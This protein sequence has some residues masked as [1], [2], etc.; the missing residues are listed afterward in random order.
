MTELKIISPNIRGIT[1]TFKRRKF[2]RN[3]H[4]SGADIIYVQETHST[5]GRER[6]WKS[7]WGGKIV[8]GHGKTNAR[9]VCILFA[10][11]L[12]V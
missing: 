7:E 6:I 1:E 3:L 11:D 12:D 10:P 8:F 5:K 9:G 2:F 4:E